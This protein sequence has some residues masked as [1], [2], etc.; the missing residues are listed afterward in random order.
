MDGRDNLRIT[1]ATTQIAV[2][3]LDDLLI[4]RIGVA[5]Q[6]ANRIEDHA[7]HAIA[8]LHCALADESFLNRMEPFVGSQAFNGENLLARSAGNR[9]TA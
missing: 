2:H 1:A 9:Y 7:R 8:A 5:L 6:K 3:P 4:A